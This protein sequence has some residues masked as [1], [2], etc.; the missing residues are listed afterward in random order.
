MP[1]DSPVVGMD[2]VQVLADSPLMRGAGRSSLDGLRAELESVALDEDALLQLDG[3]GGGAL[4]FVASGRLEIVQPLNLTDGGA[5][6]DERALATIVPGDV[7]SEMRAPTGDEGAAVLRAAT[8]VHLVT[9]SKERFDRHLGRHPEISGRL[10]TILS[11]RF[12]H[13]EL[14]RVLGEMFGDLTEELLGDIEQRLTWRHVAREDVLVRQGEPAEGLFV[15]VSGR[16]RELAETGDG[17]KVVHESVAGQVVGSTSVFSDTMQSTT[18]VA[19]RD[20]MLLEF[21]REGFRELAGR[22]PKLHEWLARLLSIRLHG[23]VHET[24]P[25]QPG[26]NI[27]LVPASEGAPLEEFARQLAEAL[28][29][30]AACALVTSARLDALLGG[31]GIAQAPE[32]SP[33]A[34]RLR[35]WLQEQETHHRYTIYVPDPTLTNWTRLCNRQADEVVAVGV[36]TAAPGLTEVEA[37]TLRCERQR[38]AKSRMTLVLL[39]PPST[40]RPRGTMQWLQERRVDRHFHLREGDRGD[41]DRFVRYVSGRE[42][43]LVLSGGGSRGFAHAGVIRAIGEAGLAIDMIAGVS[44]GA[45]IGAAFA[46]TEDFDARVRSLQERFKKAFR[47]YTLPYVSLTRGRRYNRMLQTVFG[48]TTIE[49]LWIP[50]FCVS[51]N[52]TR[53]DIVVHRTGPVWWSVRASGSLP[54][55]VPPV[56]H[57]GELLCDGCLLNNL[58]MDV[59]R[60]EIK[61]GR[62]VAVDV[63]PP[64]D[65]DLGAAEEPSSSGWTIAWKRINPL[66]EPV[67]MPG[68]VSVLQRAGTLGSIRNRQR[69]INKEIADLY[70]RPPVEQ[71]KVLDFAVADEAT[72]IGY[73]HGVTELASWAKNER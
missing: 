8:E 11:P 46:L 21:S 68:I 45:I 47:D 31:A 73:A 15:V 17:T 27:L 29:Q 16:L 52:I 50:Y 39:H 65:A 20:S 5:V 72:R 33:E 4:Y 51:S 14:V 24:R 57:N 42:F 56:V 30:R 1:P 18:V 22:Y 70:L 23:V 12:Y 10:R 62:L 60:E 37:E 40:V 34:L 32:G 35:A 55:L 44:V 66:G 7:V 64:L 41:L 67:R 53:A 71:I 2:P 43:G 26:T 69:L 19:A 54:G 61:G 38:R 59:M 58:P 3:T 49:D 6:G 9:L 28:S 13:R 48:D 25:R 63:V 36:A